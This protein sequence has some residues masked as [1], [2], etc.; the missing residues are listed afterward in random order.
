MSIARHE[1]SLALSALARRLPG[2]QP[3]DHL[4]RE[5]FH[6]LYEQMPKEFKAELIGGVVYVPLEGASNDGQAQL[7]FGDH[8]DQETFH[9]LY[10]QMPEDFKAELIG[11]VVYIPFAVSEEHGESHSSVVAWLMNYR[12]HTPGTRVL[13]DATFLLGPKSEPQP[14]AALIV[15]TELGGQTHAREIKKKRY[16]AG[17]P[18]LVVEIAYSSVAVDRYEKRSDYEQAGVREYVI[19]M[20]HEARVEWLV[21]RD[22]RYEPLAAEPDG[23]HRSTVFP[24]LWLDAAALVRGDHAQVFAALQR[25]L[26]TP[27]HEDF[28]RTL[29]A[30]RG[31]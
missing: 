21:L 4:D 5:T 19:V 9:A 18:E 22:G 11:G 1:G 13:T 15:E 30:R 26:A 20:V 31:P 6:A 8:L 24:G 25:G 17:A 12:T 14:D 28:V 10:E 23:L 29:H 16:R 3:G 7:R 27:E 2:F